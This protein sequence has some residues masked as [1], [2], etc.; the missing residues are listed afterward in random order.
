MVWTEGRRLASLTKNGKTTSYQY[1]FNRQRIL[2]TLSD[3]RKIEYF[4]VEGRTVGHTEYTSTGTQ[5]YD[6]R[7]IFGDDGSI[8]GFSYWGSGY[9][10]W[11]H[12]YFVKNLQGDVM[13]V[14]RASDNAR[15]ASYTY[16]PFGRVLTATGEMA[17][18]NPF[19]YRGY[20]YDTDTGF[21]YLQSRYY[22]PTTCRF[23]NADNI[24]N[25]AVDGD[26]ISYNL[27]AYCGNN[28]VMGSDPTGEWDW[29]TFL[30]G[31]S[32]I[33]TGAMAIAAAATVLTCGA[34][35]P[36]MVAVATVTASAGVLTVANGAA[37][38]TES[39]TGYNVIRDGAFGGD[40]AAY[41]TY[42]D[43]TKFI[44]EVGTSICGAYYSAKSGNVCFVA[45]TLVC[46]ED[47]EIPIEDIHTGDLVWAWDEDTGEVALKPVV[48]TYINQTDELLHVFVNGE[49]IVTTPTHPF[50][51]PVKGW[52]DAVHLRAGDILVHVNGEYV[53]VEEVQHEILEAPITVYN[54]QVE[55]FHPGFWC[56]WNSCPYMDFTSCENGLCYVNERSEVEE[57]VFFGGEMMKAGDD[58]RLLELWKK[59]SLEK[60]ERAYEAYMEQRKKEDL[61]YQAE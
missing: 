34:A 22:D 29:G 49:E 16:D 7:Y 6:M 11:V 30:N 39:V 59:I 18:V 36:L 25:L 19:R 21:Y 42:R 60:I 51:S 47:G 41:N 20:Y 40:E 46:T 52:T 10:A 31:A 58:A 1:D 3:G 32:L 26:V 9:T 14:Y 12:Y 54:F 56:L 61:G 37:E 55:D 4:E 45:G 35:A 27:F 28:P 5:A 57:G 48:E 17:E 13:Y 15:V 23:I 33:A 43:S 38:V 44:A 50:Y 24:T 8:V 53:V 2:K